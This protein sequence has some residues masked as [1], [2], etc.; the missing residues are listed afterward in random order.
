MIKKL[1]SI[2][3]F[4]AVSQIGNAQII[5]TNLSNG[6]FFNG[7]PYLAINPTNNQNLVS[8]WMSMTFSSGQ[9]HIAIKT[10]ASFD[11]GASWSTANL[12]PH[13]GAGFGSADPSM[14]FDKNGLLYISYIDYTQAPDSGGIYVARSNNGGLNWDTPT[15]AFDM[16]DVPNKN[17]TQLIR[18]QYTLLPSLHPGLLLQI[19][20]TLKFPMTVDIHG[21]PLQALMEERI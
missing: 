4:F 19:A 10:R 2:F 11:G 15:K 14:A 18:E 17:Q 16:Y 13:F 1:L 5:N 20:I 7:E 8:A 12:L 3:V 6:I 21:H 9:Y